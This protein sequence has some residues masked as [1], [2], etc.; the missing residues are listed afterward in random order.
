MTSR[1]HE[2]HRIRRR[3]EIYRA[4]DPDFA[5][6][7]EGHGV[8]RH[9]PETQVRAYDMIRLLV[10]EGR[11][12]DRQTG[13]RILTAAD[14]L[15][16]AA[17]WLVVHMTYAG[18]VHSDGTPLDAAD[19]KP[20]PEGHTGGSLNMVPAYAGYLAANALTGVTRSWLM[21]QGHCVAAIDAVNLLAGNLSPAQTGRYDLSDAG[22]TRFVR[23]FYS[24]EIDAAGQP[25]SPLGSHVNAHT[26]GG[27]IEGGYLGFAELLYV[28]MP[29][30]G[31]RLVAFLSDGAFEEQRASDWTPRWWRAED[32]GLV[33]PIMIA[34]GRRIDQRSTLAQ[35]GGVDWFR[36][37]LK[38][39]GFDPIDFDGRDPASFAWAICEIDDRLAACGDTARAGRETYPVPLPYGIAETE[40]GF[41]F[42]G[43]GTN[44]AH[45]LPLRGNP[46]TDRGARQEFNDGARALWVAPDDIRG[47]V[48]TLNNHHATGRPPERDHPIAVRQIAEVNLPEPPWRDVTPDTKA[49]PMEGLDAYV[50]SLVD[51]NPHLRPRIGNPDELSSNRM[52][53]TLARLKHRVSAPEPGIPE[54]IDG[55]VITALN[56]EAVVCA[57]L[58]NQ[59]GINMVVTYEAFAVKM[60]GAVRQSL[61]FARHQTEAGQPPGWL[62]VPIVATSHTWENGKNEQSHQDPTYCEALMGEMAD[63][64][65][66]VFPP[67]WNAAIA[68]LR[69]VYASRGKIW[70]MVMPKRP[71]PLRLSAF[72]ATRLMEQG[73]LRVRGCGSEDETLILVAV[74]A[75]QLEEALK[76]STRLAERDVAHSVVYILE[77]GRFRIPRDELEAAHL[78]PRDVVDGLFPK[79]AQARVFLGHTRPHTLLGVL[80]PLDTGAG[81]RALGYINRG[82]TLDVDGMLFANKCT[83]GHAIEAAASVLNIAP[84]DFLSD[85]E[86]KAVRG[87]IGPRALKWR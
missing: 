10:E 80:R 40:K 87:E 45:N 37:H 66:V 60:L 42:P 82:G 4:T 30:P 16:N 57:A 75:Y 83:W 64:S 71:T 41:G 2:Q 36:D 85:D 6:W 14:R 15:T 33:A 48:A 72:D 17:M 25:V 73:A 50:V 22:L 54:S 52:I 7:T 78:T 1:E 18:A 69:A 67:D 51:A 70:T 13:Y 3:A 55:G 8:I 11:L 47:A 76:A 68:S 20:D 53:H 28:H 44:R 81:T 84:T 56:E 34:N 86:L 46:A 49:S 59:G 27:V 38:L 23:D 58:G 26:A 63:T 12:P 39:N 32:S 19:F 5:V 29:L 62:G 35:V 21:G 31:E 61:I 43:A 65:R 77:P 79:S 9:T 24:Y 74:G